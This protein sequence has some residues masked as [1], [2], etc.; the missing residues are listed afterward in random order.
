[1]LNAM[2]ETFGR[3]WQMIERR[4]LLRGATAFAALASA[5]GVSACSFAEFDED[6]WGQ[7]L[8]SFLREGDER[9]LYEAGPA[10]RCPRW[11]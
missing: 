11:E 6:T 2:D 4:D 8:I 10:K 9:L 3:M 7:R 1:M 5:Q